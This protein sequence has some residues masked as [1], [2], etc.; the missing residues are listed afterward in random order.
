MKFHPSKIYPNGSHLIYLSIVWIVLQVLLL[1]QNGI[2]TGLEAEKYITQARYFLNHGKLASNNYYLY[3]TQIFLIAAVIKLHL[4]FPVIIGIQLVLSLYAV[5]MF[6]KMGLRFLYN[7]LLAAL[8]TLFFIL[9][10][11]YQTYNSHLFTESIFYSLSIIYSSHLLLQEKFSLGTLLWMGLLLFLLCVTRPT[12]ILFFAA[13]ACYLFFRFLHQL[14][15]FQKVLIVGSCIVVFLFIINAML[16]AGGSLDF[17]LPFR[18][19]NIICGVNTV[20]YSGIVEMKEGNSL[21]GIF[22]YIAHN[23]D[24]FFRLAKLKTF[25]F[26]GMLRTYYSVWHNIFLAIFFYPFYLFSLIGFWKKMRQRDVSLIYIVTIFFLYWVTTLLTCDDWHNRFILTVTPF[27][28]LL[29]FAAFS[30]GASDVE[31]DAKYNTT[32]Q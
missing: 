14:T 28:F 16:G 12:G 20:D 22:Y 27:F 8:A 10:I 32:R 25:A 26:F 19:E 24:Q 15:T 21:Q 4:G 6:Y 31:A 17:M 29:G 3:S 23:H 1:W 11:P 2:V 9:N 18:K 7:N 30:L 5:L 13:S